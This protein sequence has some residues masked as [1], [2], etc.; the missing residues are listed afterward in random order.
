LPAP[1]LGEFELIQRFFMRA[2][3][4]EGPRAGVTV[5]VGD[6]AAVLDLPPG[7][8]LV[9]AVDTLVEGRHFLPGTDP[10]SI[11]HR[12]LAVNLSD[13]AAMGATP[14]W[15]T[16]A[17]SMP[18]VEPA[19]LEGF[20][21]GLL[22]LADSHRV[23]LVGGDT[24]R[25]P[26]TVSVQIL[27]HVPRGSAL[28]R[29][30][31]QRGDLLVVTGTLGDAGAGLAFAKKRPK[32]S[33]QEAAVESLLARF[34]YPT[35][36]VAMG[37]AARGIASAAMDLSDGLVGDLPKLAHASGLGATVAVE[38]IPMSAAL[39]ALADEAQARDWAL[40]AGDDYELLFSVAPPRYVAL[41][42]AAQRLNL[43]LSIIGEMRA[44][45]GVSWLLDGAAFVPRSSGFDHFG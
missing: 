14:A 23:A 28:L 6:D 22:G 24:T 12:A 35:P 11:G 39:R 40:S 2:P 41:Q 27:G 31:A 38:K 1:A 26:L 7:S 20:A 9:A 32:K 8:Q 15:A 25:G 4:T 30:G 43:T 13:M 37:I 34:E 29:S 18:G 45:A 36:R 16:L 21:A 42:A 3:G 5:G 19:W 33:A 44:A 10:R 17:L